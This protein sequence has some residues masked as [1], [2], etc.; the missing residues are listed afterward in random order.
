MVNRIVL[1]CVGNKLYL[2][3]LLLLESLAHTTLSFHIYLK[4]RSY[5]WRTTHFRDGMGL[6]LLA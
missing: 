5:L 4:Y 1:F 6:Q 2:I 3:G